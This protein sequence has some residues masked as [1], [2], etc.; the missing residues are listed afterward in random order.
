MLS[1]GV[2]RRPRRSRGDER[3]L[4]E[5]D[6]AGQSAEPSRR[7]PALT[8][9]S[10][11]GFRPPCETRP[12]W[13]EQTRTRLCQSCVRLLVSGEGGEPMVSSRWARETGPNELTDLVH[14]GSSTAWSRG[15]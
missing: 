12:E 4:R 9:R 3:L 2:L 7:L 8:G 13:Q 10:H 1:A 5:R 15:V 6:G 11:C 14:R